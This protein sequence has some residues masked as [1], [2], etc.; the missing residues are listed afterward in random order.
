MQ[1]DERSRQAE[2]CVT[3]EFTYR[4]WGFC[5]VLVLLAVGPGIGV[6]GIML[7]GAQGFPTRRPLSEDDWLF[8]RFAAAWLILTAVFCYIWVYLFLCRRNALLRLNEEGIGYR[9]WRRRETSVSWAQVEALDEWRAGW[10]PVWSV[11]YRER[12]TGK[13]LWLTVY[14]GRYLAGDAG[15]VLRTILARAHL[16]RRT[17]SLLRGVGWRRERER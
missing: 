6:A 11:Q 9:D 16:T 10:F 3:G 8:V 5:L 12:S 17:F 2:E 14:G 1:R 13:P 15:E 4:S 7:A